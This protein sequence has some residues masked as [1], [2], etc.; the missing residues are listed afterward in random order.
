MARHDIDTSTNGPSLGL[1]RLWLLVIA[2]LVGL[3]AVV[4][5]ATRLT[6]SGLSITEWNGIGGAMPPLTDPHWQ[7]V[8]DKYQTLPQYR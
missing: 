8:F 2:G 1:V 7:D 4:G 5:A 3:T 6:G